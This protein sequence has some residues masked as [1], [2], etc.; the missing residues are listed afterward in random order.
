MDFYYAMTNYHVLCC[1]I[2]KLLI[3]KNEGTLYLSSFLQYNQPNIVNNIKKSK[4]FEE[5]KFYD[6]LEF[7]KTEKIMNKND[8][9]NEIKRINNL[10]EKSIGQ[11]IK[12]ADNIYLCSDFYSIG[13]YVNNNNIKYSYFEDGCGILS[14]YYMPFKILEKENPNRALIAKKQGAFGNNKNVINRFG[15]LKEQEEGYSNPK[16]IDFSVKDLLKKLSK[17]DINKLLNI[18]EVKKISIKNN[19]AVLFLTMHYNEIMSIENQKNIYSTLLDYFTEEKEKIIIKP[20]PADTIFNYNKIFKNSTTLNRFMPSELFPYC[21]EGKFKSGLTCYSTAIYG[22]KNMLKEI[23]AFDVKIDKTY[24]QMDKYYAIE[25]Y[26]KKIKT[27]KVIH[28]Y[29]KNINEIQLKMLLEKYFVDY[30][31]YYTFNDINSNNNSIYIVDKITD[32]LKENKVISL[33][34]DVYSKK[35][36]SISNK[37]KE[38]NSFIGLYNFE[39]TELNVTKKLNCSKSEIIIK[40]ID[41]NNKMEEL[42]KII[43]EKNITIKKQ[44]KLYERKIESIKKELES[45]RQKLDKIYN[46]KSWI[47]LEKLRKI[48]RLFK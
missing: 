18:F 7:K 40:Y 23:I 9:N 29:L 27:D 32:D 41:E 45:E 39:K 17:K 28:L 12:S 25:E 19:N 15:S 21:I 31:K 10:V 47:F 33:E 5:V 11:V 4:I 46:S 37:K 34:E 30:K 43:N 6:E 8:I 3:N 1:L 36:I 44:E 42:Y 26:L 14:R 48:K 20:H 13:V 16:D 38:E 22:L 35:F 24:N 2:H